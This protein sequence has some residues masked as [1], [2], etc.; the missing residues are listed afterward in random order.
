M[1]QRQRTKT[2]DFGFV[3]DQSPYH[4]VVDTRLDN[5]VLI[6]ERYVWGD[7]LSSPKGR[8]VRL[9]AKLDDY[10]WSYV[11]DKVADVFNRQ[12]S[13]LG[14]KG[15]AFRKRGETVL[16][17]P[18]GKELTL[19]A[20]AIEDQ[21]PSLLPNIFFNWA[22]LAPEERWWLYTTINA[23]F[24]DANIGKDRGWRKAIKI[25]FAENSI[26]DVPPS[27]LLNGQ[28][29]DDGGER[30]RWLKEAS[31]RRKDQEPPEQRNLFDEML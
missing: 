31:E 10:R 15:T 11:V 12:L 2:Y 1:T 9:K 17:P 25:A 18:L 22:G 16:S 21:D 3:P 24:Q 27:S 29:S 5:Y 14:Q 19:L 28:L 20:W 8:D 23:T 4:F 26:G 13:R 6:V 30:A 7:E